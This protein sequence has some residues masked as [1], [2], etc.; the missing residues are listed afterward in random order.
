[1]SPLFVSALGSF[2]HLNT[3]LVG[4]LCASSHVCGDDPSCLYTFVF[5][6][7]P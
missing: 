2:G 6:L 4:G 7:L 3:C 5:R 1:M